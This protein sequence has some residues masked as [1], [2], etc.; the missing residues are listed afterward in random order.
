MDGRPMMRRGEEE[1]RR[2]YK[3]N[4]GFICG[5]RVE[6]QEHSQELPNVTEIDKVGSPR[7][8]KHETGVRF[9]GVP[10]RARHCFSREWIFSGKVD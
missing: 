3:E 4:G 7:I 6:G 10:G 9:H 2:W 8:E 1:G 5:T